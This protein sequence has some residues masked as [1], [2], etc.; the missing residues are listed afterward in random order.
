MNIFVKMETIDGTAELSK[1]VYLD[2]LISYEDEKKEKKACFYG[3]SIKQDY[4]NLHPCE[5][6]YVS[7]Y[8]KPCLCDYNVSNPRFNKKIE[9]DGTLT[10]TVFDKPE[11]IYPMLQLFLS[12]IDKKH[13]K[14]V[15]LIFDETTAMTH[16]SQMSTFLTLL[17]MYVLDLSSTTIT[18]EFANL[19]QRYLKEDKGD[20]EFSSKLM[21][22]EDMK[23]L[24]EEYLKF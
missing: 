18:I 22:P 14:N 13:F 21:S 7:E 5:S 8:V 4:E 10:M 12:Q 24:C 9:S 20:Y 17:R 3:Q 16:H 6:A 19:K 1:L 15:N 11:E 23:L 2:L